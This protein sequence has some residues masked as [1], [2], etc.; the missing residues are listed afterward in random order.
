MRSRGA[1]R[2][3]L[4][5]VDI[6]EALGARGII[7]RAHSRGLLA[8]EASEAYKDVANVVRVSDGAGITRKV[9]RLRPLA[10]IKG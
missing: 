10:V 3:L 4:Q 2:R 1:A 9:A 5:G 7:V 8:E 6:V